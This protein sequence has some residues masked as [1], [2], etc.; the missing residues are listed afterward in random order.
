MSIVSPSV[1]AGEDFATESL[2]VFN[3]GTV[4]LTSF[5]LTTTPAQPTAT[6]CL[7]LTD[8]GGSGTLA[9][10]CPSMAEGAGTVTVSRTV[11]PGKGVVVELLI[12]GASFA[13]GGE[14]TITVAA[15]SGAAQT[16]LVR[17]VPA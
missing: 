7:S 2:T 3:D 11:A 10:S 9:T 16:V 4:P 13:V 1:R 6:Y 15:S 5:A 8:P 17:V 12:R 14:V